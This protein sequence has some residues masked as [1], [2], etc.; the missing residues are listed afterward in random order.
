MPIES[1]IIERL[2]E[3]GWRVT[4]R[5]AD[6]TDITIG[7]FVSLWD[8]QE[9][10]NWKPDHPT[11]NPHAKLPLQRQGPQQAR[12]IDMATAR[13]GWPSFQSAH[14]NPRGA[15]QRLRRHS[16]SANCRDYPCPA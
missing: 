8:A 7:D 12:K 2:A 13:V 4:E 10:V 1:F 6:L 9:W 15:T 14:Q 5:R 16:C 11:A 3:D